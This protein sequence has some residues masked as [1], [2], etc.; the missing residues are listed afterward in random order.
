MI[1]LK[2]PKERAAK[3]KMAKAMHMK[4]EKPVKF[5]PVHEPEVK[6]HVEKVKFAIPKSGRNLEGFKAPGQA[7]PPK[8]TAY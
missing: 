7:K 2:M 1:G 4:P 8:A 3:V 6:A 5:K